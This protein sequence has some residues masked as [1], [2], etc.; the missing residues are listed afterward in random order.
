M[1]FFHNHLPH[2]AERI[3]L[4]L[5]RGY[6]AKDLLAPV[7]FLWSS[8]HRVQVE[9]VGRRRTVMS[10]QNCSLVWPWS[11]TRLACPEGIYPR[12]RPLTRSAQPLMKRV[13]DDKLHHG[14]RPAE[15]LY[16]LSLFSKQGRREH[17]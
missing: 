9:A 11:R 5:P 8:I 1:G 14:Q 2:L 15:S 13:R 10:C 4:A 6:G 17:R 16:Q 7:E 3:V 12:C